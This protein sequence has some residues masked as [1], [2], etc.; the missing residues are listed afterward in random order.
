LNVGASAAVSR[1][2][3]EQQEER[4]TTV[5]QEEKRVEGTPE[6]RQPYR[7]EKEEKDEKDRRERVEKQEKEQ[8]R[9]PLSNVMGALFLIM[10]GVI[11]LI[12]AQGWITWSEFGGLWNLFFIGAGLLLLLEA[13]LRLMLPAYR[14]PILG[15][16]VGGM[17]LLAIGLGGMTRFELTG[18]IILIGIGL[19]ILLGGL[20]RGRL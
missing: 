8:R 12:Q 5:S 2:H 6:P 19:A 14:R 9:D 20:F 13:A 7:G 17:V 1:A 16:I 11:L 3:R 15:Q 4:S 18:P 10:L